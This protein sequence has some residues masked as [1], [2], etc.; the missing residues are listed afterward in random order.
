MGWCKVM[1]TSETSESPAIVVSVLFNVPIIC[2][3]VTATL[4]GNPALLVLGTQGRGG[5]DLLDLSRLTAGSH[6]LV[7][8]Y[9]NALWAARSLRTNASFRSAPQ[10]KILLLSH[11]DGEADVR[12]ALEYGIQ[13]YLP[14]D[15]QPE[16]MTEGVVSL[17]RGMRCLGRVAAQRVAESFDY[18]AL[19][20]RETEVLRCVV[21]GDA[22]KIV[23]KKLNIALG[24]V[25]VHV[26]SIMSKLGARTRTEAAA[27]A[28][29]R[30]LFWTCAEVDGGAAGRPAGGVEGKAILSPLPS[31]S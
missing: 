6:V 18:E 3:G 28:R 31:Y 8:D 7:A 19:T 16:E 29:R 13:G 9:D 26:G 25:K 11:R 12:R 20:D 23:A 30:G 1:I 15:C 24:T 14:L 10:T 21:A 22:N 5:D 17:Y 27:V 2:A 4:R